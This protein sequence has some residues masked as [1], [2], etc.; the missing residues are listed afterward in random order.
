[1]K[2]LRVQCTYEKFGFNLEGVST[3]TSI[4]EFNNGKIW[5]EVKIYIFQDHSLE[6]K[7]PSTLK[8]LTHEDFQAVQLS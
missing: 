6:K 7:Q 8:T 5:E 1:M 3:E 4:K 2:S